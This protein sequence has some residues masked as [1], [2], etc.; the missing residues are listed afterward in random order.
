M[1]SSRFKLLE[2]MMLVLRV[3]RIKDA[4]SVYYY[5]ARR[6]LFFNHL[7]CFISLFT[8]LLFFF[9]SGKGRKAFIS[10]FLN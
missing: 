8:S 3:F 10:S 7:I 4:V 1:V 9:F 2:E 6:S 5:E